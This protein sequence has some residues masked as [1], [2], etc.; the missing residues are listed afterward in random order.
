MATVIVCTFGLSGSG[1]S[2]SASRAWQVAKENVSSRSDNGG[3]EMLKVVRVFFIAVTL[4]QGSMD[5]R[6][7]SERHREREQLS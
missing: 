3:T 4:Y 5:G 2:N 1:T 6:F 7:A